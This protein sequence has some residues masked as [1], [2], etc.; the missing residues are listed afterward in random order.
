MNYKKIIIVTVVTSLLVILSVS[1]VHAQTVSFGSSNSTVTFGFSNSTLTYGS[2]STIPSNS[3]VSLGGFSNSKSVP[4]PACVNNLSLSIHNQGLQINISKAILLASENS[5]YLSMMNGYN[6]SSPT[7]FLT[8]T[9]DK[10][11]CVNILTG[12]NVGYVLR[13]QTVYEKSLVITLDPTL[14]KVTNVT[15]YVGPYYLPSDPTPNWSGYELSADGSSNNPQTNL[16]SSQMS[17]FIPPISQ[18]SA[19][20]NSKSCISPS[21]GCELATWTGLEDQFGANPDNH[22]VQGG[23]DENMTCTA[24]GSCNS[25]TYYLWFEFLPNPAFLCFNSNIKSGDSITDTVSNNG[26][27][28]YSISVV[29]N[30]ASATCATIQ[31]S[32][33]QMTKPVPALSF[34]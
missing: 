6:S 18:P 26:N 20:A 30:A 9:L 29:D 33:P 17:Y 25:V 4:S 19:S 27:G 10:T 22:L 8:G 2:N 23:T 1:Y 21:I 3:T 11:N 5:R 14:S 24:I 32:Y 7:I 16:T 34:M 12:V 28:V 13:N 31:Q 15:S